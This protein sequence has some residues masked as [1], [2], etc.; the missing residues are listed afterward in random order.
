MYAQWKLMSAV[1][2]LKWKRALPGPDIINFAPRGK[3]QKPLTLESLLI[4]HYAPPD[5]WE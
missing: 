3:F 4:N 1:I 2:S 5:Y